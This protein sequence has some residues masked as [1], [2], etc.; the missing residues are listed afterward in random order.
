MPWQEHSPVDL[1]YSFIVDWQLGIVSVCELCEAYG[2][3][4]KTGYKWIARFTAGGAPAL[5]DQSRRPHSS[6][7]ASRT[8]VI[9]AVCAA[10]RRHPLWGARKLGLWLGRR[11]P[12]QAWPSRVTLQAILQRAGLQPARRSRPP[13]WR[14]TRVHT[15]ATGPNRVW[16][17]DFKGDFRLGD[18]TRCYPLTVRDLATRYTLTCRGLAAP[19]RERTQRWVDAAFAEF[20]LPDCIRSDNGEPFAGPGLGGLSRLNVRWLRLGIRIE[21]IEPGCPAQNGAHEQFHRVLKAHT[22]R[23]PAL[24]ARAQQQRFDRFCQLYNHERPHDGLGGDVPA[25]HYHPSRRPWPQRVPE[26]DYPAHWERRTVLPNG[27]IRWDGDAMFLSRALAGEAV[28]LEEIDDGLW[29]VHFAT[30]ALAYWCA[31]QRRLRPIGH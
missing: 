21:Q 22:T 3:S 30:T 16:T 2:I 9:D 18:G 13:R 6:P 4:R 5:A 26:V 1:R 27:R 10:H 24:T 8:A 25:D 23:P 12:T 17:V 20:G 29:T 14:S 15:P 11:Y 31:R 7:H 19:A 28:G